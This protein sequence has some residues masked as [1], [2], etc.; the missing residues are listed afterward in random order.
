MT[1]M[2]IRDRLERN[3]WTTIHLQAGFLTN[4]ADW[5][6]SCRWKSRLWHDPAFEL[7][8]S[9]RLVRQLSRGSEWRWTRSLERV[10]V[11]R[12]RRRGE[13]GV[14]DAGT[15][16]SDAGGRLPDGRRRVRCYSVK[17]RA[18]RLRCVS[19][20][21]RLGVLLLLLL[22]LVATVSPPAEEFAE[23]ESVAEEREKVATAWRAAQVVPAVT[24]AA[25]ARSRCCCC[26]SPCAGAVAG[27]SGRRGPLCA[28]INDL[29]ARLGIEREL[30]EPPEESRVVRSIYESTHFSRETVEN[31]Q[32][33]YL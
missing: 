18:W 6:C 15:G 30:H 20:S 25:A 8:V 3:T 24:S 28:C 16:A 26:C 23:V 4:I 33:M 1:R 7:L 11:E 5:S 29:A 22:P 27:C 32:V 13:R 2:N 31:T 17:S 9:V 19:W 21:C 12:C 10:R 14:R